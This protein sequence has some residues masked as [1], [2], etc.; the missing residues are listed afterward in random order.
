LNKKLAA[1]ADA[2]A[3][4]RLSP[5]VMLLPFCF[6]AAP[7]PH[8]LMDG[9]YLILSVRHSSIPRGLKTIRLQHHSLGLSLSLY[10]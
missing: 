1:D 3:A 2:D 8:F 4:Y 7:G 5:L 9:G 10:C 6:M